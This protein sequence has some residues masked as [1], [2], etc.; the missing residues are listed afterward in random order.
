MSQRRRSGHLSCSLHH[1]SRPRCCR[2]KARRLAYSDPSRTRPHV[3]EMESYTVA[4]GRHAVLCAWLTH[5]VTPYPI[6]LRRSLRDARH[7]G[8]LHR[9]TVGERF[10][11]DACCCED[12]DAVAVPRTRV[13]QGPALRTSE[14]TGVI[15]EPPRVDVLNGTL[16]SSSSPIPVRTA[17]WALEDRRRPGHSRTDDARTAWMRGLERNLPAVAS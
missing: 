12:E 8:I 10:R 2:Q 13:G 4:T 3:V 6:A 1:P 11:Q 15:R 17:C 7:V 5:T 9:S 14:G 16:A